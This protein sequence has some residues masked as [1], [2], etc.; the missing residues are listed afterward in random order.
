[1]RLNRVALRMGGGRRRPRARR[2]SP[3]PGAAVKA[4]TEYVAGFARRCRC[5]V[6]CS[7]SSYASTWTARN[8]QQDYPVYDTATGTFAPA[9]ARRRE[10]RHAAGNAHH[11][12]RLRILGPR[13]RRATA[14]SANSSPRPPVGTAEA[15]TTGSVRNDVTCAT[16]TAAARAFL[17][18]SRQPYVEGQ[19]IYLPMPHPLLLLRRRLRTQRAG[20]VRPLPGG[21]QQPLGTCTCVAGQCVVPDNPNVSTTA[22]RPSRRTTTP[23]STARRTP[24]FVRSTTPTP[25][26]QLQPGCMDY[27]V[28]AAAVGAPSDCV[29]AHPDDAERGRRRRRTRTRI[30][31]RRSPRPRPTPGPEGPGLNVRAVFDN[32]V[33]EVLDYEGACPATWPPPAGAYPKRATARTRTRRRSSGSRPACASSTSARAA[34]TR[35]RC[36]RRAPFARR[37]RRSSRSATTAQGRPSPRSSTAGSSAGRRL[38]RGQVR[39]SRRRARSTSCSTSRAGCATSSGTKGLGEVLGLSLTNPV[40][41]Q[42]S[43]RPRCTRPRQAADCSSSAN[44][45]AHDIQ[46]DAGRDAPRGDRPLR[47]RRGSPRETS[48]TACSTRGRSTRARSRRA[49]APGTS[50]PRSPGAY[51]GA[52]EHQRGFGIQSPRGDA[53]LRSQLQRGRRHGLPAAASRC[54]HGGGRRRSRKGSRRTPSIS[55]TRI[56]P[57]AASPGDPAAA[58]AQ[59]ARGLA[60]GG[61]YFFNA[62]A[63]ASAQATAGEALASVVADLGSCVYEVPLHFVPGSQ[64]TFPDYSYTP[65]SVRERRSAPSTVSVSYATSCATTTRAGTRSTS[66]TTSTFESA[67][68]PASASSRASSASE[69]LSAARNQGL[70][71][72][73][74]PLPVEVELGLPVQR[75]RFPTRASSSRA[76]RP[77]P[78]PDAGPADAGSEVDAGGK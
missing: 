64:L 6:T 36:S 71:T 43:R 42:T 12:H 15:S 20:N 21:G 56:T 9:D 44:E 53:L 28:D 38:R 61:T 3:G 16:R 14:H 23:S 11:D 62:A 74:P 34:R 54:D 72:P 5:R 59:L 52:P 24:A 10:R 22:R 67:R 37:R 55:R 25:P 30:S 46:A 51:H 32:V 45:F 66:S 47:V 69:I 39:S 41:Q 26:R 76:R 33:S 70:M 35:S 63:G 8:F 4:V 19:I 77:L 18:A 48:R 57:M 17:R 40:F 73:L 27:E 50:R 65:A 68:T 60:P 13:Q 2:R 49:R 7:R 58:G 29:F 78:P 75:I 31:R 1:M